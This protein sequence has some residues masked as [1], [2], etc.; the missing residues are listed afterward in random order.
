MTQAFD[1]VWPRELLVKLSKILPKQ[2]VELLE[3]YLTDRLFRVKEDDDY[4]ELKEIRAGVPQGSALGPL[5]YLLYTCD[6]PQSEE[7]MIATFADDTAILAV[8]SSVDEA[9]QQLNLASDKILKWTSKWRI[10]LNETKSVHVNFT[11]KRLESPPRV[12]IGDIKVPHGNT[13]KYLGMTLDAKLRWKEHVKK[14]KEE[15]GLKYRELYWLIGRNSKVSIENKLKIYN[16]VLKPV[17]LY[18]IQLWGCA[19][20]SHIRSIQTFQNKVLRNIVNAPWYVRNTDIHRDLE[21]PYVV[22]EV[23]KFAVKH[24]D[25]LFQ[26]PNEE[27]RE[28]LDQRGLNR[29][30][31]RTKPFELAFR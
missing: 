2:Y 28:L 21:M 7:T 8:A 13:A 3:S 1:K 5:L 9:T 10:K 6:V 17:W 12:F 14:K 18:G 11:N 20:K 19:K 26:H 4:S 30:L 22:S 24:E 16:Q 25:R 31:K 15:L 27:V 29:R 23:K